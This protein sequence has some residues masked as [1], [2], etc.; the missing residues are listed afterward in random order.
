MVVYLIHFAALYA[1][2][3]TEVKPQP[4]CNDLCCA[5]GYNHSGIC[6]T[7]TKCSKEG[8]II[9]KSG[10]KTQDNR[11]W[12]DGLKGYAPRRPKECRKTNKPEACI[13]I[14]C[15][16][17]KL[18][19]VT[20]NGQD[21]EDFDGTKHCVSKCALPPGRNITTSIPDISDSTPGTCNSGALEDM[22]IAILVLAIIETVIMSIVVGLCIC[23]RE[24][25]ASCLSS[26]RRIINDRNNER[27][28]PANQNNGRDNPASQQ[29]QQGRPAKSQRD[30]QK[31]DA[32]GSD[33]PLTVALQN[34]EPHE[35]SD[36]ATYAY[37]KQNEKAEGECP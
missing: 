30:K 2:A 5:G 9:W 28:N 16:D 1:A 20:E 7:L 29:Q 4:E 33:E 14:R 19:N 10:N 32:S 27:D 18:P 22:I 13:C 24:Q 31:T 15:L 21:V 6:K 12:C 36:H 17:G 23:Y 8:Q 37:M 26:L 35:G 3:I 25:I 34:T 11:C